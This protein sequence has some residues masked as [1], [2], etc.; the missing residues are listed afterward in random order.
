M[1]LWKLFIVIGLLSLCLAGF[2][3]GM[4]LR[5]AAI[6]RAYTDAPVGEPLIVP[7]IGIGIMALGYGIAYRRRG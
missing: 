4:S 7:L 5:E 6:I 2:L 3:V 1:Q